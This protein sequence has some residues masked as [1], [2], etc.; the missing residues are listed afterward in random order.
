MYKYSHEYIYFI[1]E[2][3]VSGCDRVFSVFFFFGGGGAPNKHIYIMFNP[4]N[5]SNQLYYWG[6]KKNNYFIY[7]C[8]QIRLFTCLK[9][10]NYYPNGFIFMI[11]QKQLF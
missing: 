6:L 5:E 11:I 10:Y 8:V 4:L 7:V 3:S 9:K 2:S 1:R